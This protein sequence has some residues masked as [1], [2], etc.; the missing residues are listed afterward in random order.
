MIVTIEVT[1]D[2]IAAGGC[3]CTDCPVY[4]EACRALP[5]LNGVSVTLLGIYA[6]RTSPSP[7]DDPGYF[8]FIELPEDVSYRIGRYDGGLGMEPF[9]FEADVP[10]EL[11]AAVTP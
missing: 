6:A 4:F 1:A 9:S 10:G 5:W 8:P 7:D 2:D 3:G 11:L